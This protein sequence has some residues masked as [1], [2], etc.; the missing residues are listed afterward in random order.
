MVLGDFT[1][2][3]FTIECLQA[4]IASSLLTPT[5]P[6]QLSLFVSD[7]TE[8]AHSDLL[9]LCRSVVLGYHPHYFSLNVLLKNTVHMLVFSVDIFENFKLSGK[10]GSCNVSFTAREFYLYFINHVPNFR[11]IILIIYFNTIMS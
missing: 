2:I 9:A 6:L 8:A 10:R 7:S 4:P 1:F 5:S 3:C 11:F